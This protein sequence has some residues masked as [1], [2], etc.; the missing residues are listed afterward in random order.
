MIL[1][2]KIYNRNFYPIK[3]FNITENI[4]DSD[5]LTKSNSQVINSS[6]FNNDNGLLIKPF[7]NIEY[8]T[9]LGLKDSNIDYKG[10]IY[11]D[12]TIYT[13]SIDY[14]TFGILT[15]QDVNIKHHYVTIKTSN[16][17]NGKY[18]NIITKSD[19]DN[20]SENIIVKYSMKDVEDQNDILNNISKCGFNSYNIEDYDF[21]GEG[22]NSIQINP[23]QNEKCF[24]Q[25]IR[26]SIINSQD[27]LTEY[28]NTNNGKLKIYKK[29]DNVYFDM[30][31]P[32]IMFSTLFSNLSTSYYDMIQ[33]DDYSVSDQGTVDLPMLQQ[34]LGMSVILQLK[35]NNGNTPYKINIKIITP[36][37]FLLKDI[38][39]EIPEKYVSSVKPILNAI[40]KSSNIN[41]NCLIVSPSKTKLLTN[42]NTQYSTNIKLYPLSFSALN[43]NNESNNDSFF[44]INSINQKTNDYYTE[45]GYI[46]FINDTLPIK[47]ILSVNDDILKN[48]NL[49]ILLDTSGITEEYTNTIVINYSYDG[50]VFELE[51][52]INIIPTIN[53]IKPEI[54]YSPNSIIVENSYKHKIINNSSTYK[55][56]VDT[57]HFSTY[58]NDTLNFELKNIGEVNAIITDV[59]IENAYKILNDL[60]NITNKTDDDIENISL[61][62]KYTDKHFNSMSYINDSL[63]NTELQKLISYD[64]IKKYITFKLNTIDQK[65]YNAFNTTPFKIFFS[66]NKYK[67]DINYING[68]P[69]VIKIKYKSNTS[70]II[71]EKYFCD[72]IDFNLKFVLGK[73]EL[74]YNSNSSNVKYVRPSVRNTLFID[75]YK[76][77]KFNNIQSNI[78][79]YLSN[80]I[81]IKNAEIININNTNNIN[82]SEYF[83]NNNQYPI[84]VSSKDNISVNT[85]SFDINL[86]K[87]KLYKFNLKLYTNYEYFKYLEIPINIVST[88]IDIENIITFDE[89]D[90]YVKNNR[91][92]LSLLKLETKNRTLTINNKS[93]LDINILN[94]TTYV[95]KDKFNESNFDISILTKV[96]YPFILNNKNNL[97]LNINFLG[98][99]YGHYNCF[100]I[101]KTNLGDVYLSIPSYVN[102][103]NKDVYVLMEN[104]KGT[105]FTATLGN[106]DI[107]YIKLINFG[108]DKC[109]TEITKL[110]GANVNN[111]NVKNY[112]TLLP[113][114]TNYI[115]N[116]F[117]PISSG[118]KIGY[119]NFKLNDMLETFKLLEDSSSY[120]YKIQNSN[121][122][123]QMNGVG[124]LENA[125]PVFSKSVIDFGFISL[126][127]K[128]RFIRVD[129]FDIVNYGITPFLITK[130]TKVNKNSPFSILIDN[131]QYP[132]KVNDKI[133]INI[134]IDN[135]K[136]NN[137]DK[138]YYDIIKFEM[139]DLKTKNVF[140][141]DLIVKIELTESNKTY[142]S[143]NSE[144]IE[145]GYC[146]INNF[147]TDTVYIKNFSTEKLTLDVNY[148]GNIELQTLDNLSVNI[149]PNQIFNLP[150]YFYPHGVSIFEGV[151]NLSF[152]NGN[153]EKNINLMGYGVDF[154]LPLI[155][156]KNDISEYMDKIQKYL[157]Y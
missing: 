39:Q 109:F 91:Y 99:D 74:F 128:N 40:S 2:T 20:L 38:E 16:L 101:L 110:G 143:L 102:T 24:S 103:K 78:G 116:V 137:N 64:T 115:E 50:T 76:N 141:N 147:K 69:L 107:D 58:G 119:L 67:E 18:G 75:L 136:F 55:T 126:E 29:D 44:T 73:L 19:I 145:F 46:Y 127:K 62:T 86:Q 63:S 54:I 87:E 56:Y 30:D 83:L 95:I 31:I 89:N 13:D 98:K 117:K 123:A 82:S 66:L 17:I 139:Q 142:V 97:K 138:I 84:S 121:I 85:L 57:I 35:N 26:G 153:Y 49:N 120:T 133:S 8:L 135:T 151:I 148:N 88:N 65:E 113:N 36:I 72:N 144:F 43:F 48:N 25:F 118:K 51:T 146:E 59:E 81:V 34:S 21:F 92:Y 45:N 52:D 5:K 94:I 1:K 152:N 125:L 37:I 104:T 130:I 71:Y 114:T 68:T 140:S 27:T 7:Q 154:K 6:S 155:K 93:N 149:Q 105:S 134:Y 96:K 53:S 42:P 3:I 70:N 61:L 15:G 32:K 112:S 4:L 80:S 150:I 10:T 9:S 106:S 90:F 47:K 129:N 12:S 11:L 108:D 14:G 156:I 124:L 131:N 33:S 41:N 100:I 28:I 111:F 122:I 60:N 22:I 79:K 23:S 77:I 157:K 132:I